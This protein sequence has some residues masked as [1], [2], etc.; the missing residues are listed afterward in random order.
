ML[1]KDLHRYAGQPLD[2]PHP[3][4]IKCFTDSDWAG[5]QESRK[6][7]FTGFV[8]SI[9]NTPLSF[10]SKT[11]GSIAQSSA[12]AEHYAMASGVADA[13]FIRQLLEE[14]QEHI[15]IK[16]FLISD[17]HPVSGKSLPSITVLTDSTSATSLVQKMGLNRRSK[18][19]E[20]KYLWLQDHHKNG[21]IKVKRVSSQEI[22][23]TSLPKM[24]LHLPWQN[25]FLLVGFKNFVLG[26]GMT[27][28]IAA[29][30]TF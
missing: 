17:K 22:Q 21:V 14:I 20:L 7:T 23:Q 6:P 5:D 9:V 13:I 28:I 27:V 12:E 1:G 30:Y 18:H 16:T 10:S 11:Q 26:E 15:G 2:R 3:L 25:I 19:I 24:C 8:I 4:D 29:F